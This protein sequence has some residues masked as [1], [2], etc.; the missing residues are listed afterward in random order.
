MDYRANLLTELR[1]SEDGQEGMKVETSGEMGKEVTHL[2]KA[3]DL[4]TEL[5]AP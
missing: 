4:L 5:K 3:E 2:H 1:Q